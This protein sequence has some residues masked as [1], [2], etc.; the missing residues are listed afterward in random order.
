MENEM[1]KQ[2]SEHRNEM[3]Q[4]A[5]KHY[6]LPEFKVWASD[7]CM[8][9]AQQIARI[10]TEKFDK[11]DIIKSML[12]VEDTCCI[13]RMLM[14]KDEGMIDEIATEIYCHFA[15]MLKAHGVV[16]ESECSYNKPSKLTVQTNSLK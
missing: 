11:E 16:L 14:K 8:E 13:L 5:Y 15:E 6:T 7:V 12:M 1:D 3:V 2:L 9:L 10:N 4:Q